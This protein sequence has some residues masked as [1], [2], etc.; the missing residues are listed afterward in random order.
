[1]RMTRND[2]RPFEKTLETING[3]YERQGRA[4]VSKVAPPVRILGWGPSQKVIFLENP[5]V[6][7]T[8]SWTEMG[9]RS[10]HFE[11]K[12]T[13]KPTLGINKSELKPTQIEAMRRWRAAGAATFLLWEMDN[14]IMFFTIAMIEAGATARRSLKFEDGHRVESG[15]GF[16]FHDYLATAKRF[17]DYL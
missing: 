8:G 16:V 15:T 9:G 17:K 7:F 10:L 5:F 14:T 2:G 4:T 13:T 12:S 6:D 11:S 1:M 3:H